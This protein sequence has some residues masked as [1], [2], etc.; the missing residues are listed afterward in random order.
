MIFVI[1]NEK[2]YSDNTIYFVD[3]SPAF[4]QWFDDVFVPW[5]NRVYA[6]GTPQIIFKAEALEW[7]RPEDMC[8]PVGFWDHYSGWSD[9]DVIP[10]PPS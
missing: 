9:D 5:C 6:Y 1:D 4:E 3:A 10:G 8:T 2:D 7:R